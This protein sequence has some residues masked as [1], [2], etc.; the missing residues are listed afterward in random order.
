MYIGIFIL[1]ALTPYMYYKISN[2]D[3]V[4]KTSIFSI[5]NID[6]AITR[7][8]D[9]VQ[10]KECNF[11][12]YATDQLNVCLSPSKVSSFNAL[13][14]GDSAA[15]TVSLAFA[16][17]I[18]SM[19]GNAYIST[20]HGCPFIELTR[21]NWNSGRL[22]FCDDFN[23]F[24][25]TWI[26]RHN[27]D[28][29]FIL[30]RSTAYTSPNILIGD[31]RDFNGGAMCIAEFDSEIMV[32]RRSCLDRKRSLEIYEKALHKT[33][34]SIKNV[35]EIYLIGMYPE[36][37][38]NCNIKIDNSC[39]YMYRND[40][41]ERGFGVNEIHKKLDGNYINVI[42]YNPINLFCEAQIC[43]NLVRGMNGYANSSH[44]NINGSFLFIS[45][46]KQIINNTIK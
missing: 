41:V 20:S 9:D 7:L 35:Q 15:G 14:I 18:N 3:T 38:P 1:T 25:K 10:F 24:I 40:V 12:A 34:N 2:N 33:I 39:N 30:N 21:W 11:A 45:Y 32:D 16:E 26:N 44:L 23:D 6:T 37:E 5:E 46:F 27:P 4:S 42:F 29:I 17:A 43:S 13:L 31:E 28:K 8:A 36:L 22:D 19:N